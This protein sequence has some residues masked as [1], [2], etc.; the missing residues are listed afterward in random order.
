MNRARSF[1][2]T[3]RDAADLALVGVATTVAS[4]PV[5]TAGAAVGTASAA[6]HDR[7]TR[8]SFP[9][10]ATTWH[11]FVRALLPGLG[12]TV[13][14][15]GVAA[16]ILLDV[17]A[18]QDDVVPGGTALLAATAVASAMLLGFAGLTI[19]EVGRRD[20]RGWTAAARHG[21]SLGL[22]RP[23]ALAAGAG[24]SLLAVVL[25]AMVPVTAPLVL[26]YL[27][28]AFHVVGARATAR[29]RR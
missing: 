1:E 18:V 13:V 22:S 14:G 7:Y 24:A 25:A 28:F 19:A 23:L 16:L 27:L 21:I 11:R 8:G 9:D 2:D 15:A 6:I 29:V 17:S 26:G 4:L 20:G 10:L 5:L 3:L 12:A